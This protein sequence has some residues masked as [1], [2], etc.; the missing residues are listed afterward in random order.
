MEIDTGDH[1]PITQR[2][3]SLA[4]KHVEWMQEEI[5]K[6]E[7]AGVI[8]RSMSPWASPIVIVPKKT[9]PGEPPRR[10]MCVDYRMVNS[11]APPVVKAHSKAKVVLTFVPLPKIDEIFAKLKGSQIYSTFDM[12]SGYYHLEL[13]KEA[14]AKTVFVI[15]GPIGENG[16]SSVSLWFNPGASLFSKTGTSSFRGVDICFWIFR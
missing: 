7:Q 9:A 3:Y 12:R 14:Q 2:P 16:N 8:T 13:S 1:P 10:R 5:E 4:L 11:L 15:G 6:L